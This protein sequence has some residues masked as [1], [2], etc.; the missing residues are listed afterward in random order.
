MRKLMDVI[1]QIKKG[2]KVQVKKTFCKMCMFM[3]P[4]TTKT[5]KSERIKS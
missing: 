1:M 5:I 4:K 2:L 3:L